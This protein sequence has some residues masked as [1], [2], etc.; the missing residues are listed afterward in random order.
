MHSV[1]F[2]N[3]RSQHEHNKLRSNSFLFLYHLPT[4]PINNNN[5]FTTTPPTLT[6]WCFFWHSCFQP[7]HFQLGC[8]RRNQFCKWLGAV[9][10][11]FIVF[12]FSRLELCALSLLLLLL[13]SF[14]IVHASVLF[15]LVVSI[16]KTNLGL[17]HFFFCSIYHRTLSS[18]TTYSLLLLLLSQYAMFQNASAFNQDISEWVVTNGINFVSGLGLFESCWW[19]CFHVLSSV[20]CLCCCYPWWVSILFMHSILFIV[21]VSMNKTN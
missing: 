5:I 10:I 21:V 19:C 17:T 18:T 20:H 8:H 7:R 2:M 11:V 1:L 14:C 9:G 4:A 16:N 15:M 13:M 3:A 6:G 12:L